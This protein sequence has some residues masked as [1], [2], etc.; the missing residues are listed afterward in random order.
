[1]K[2][3][4]SDTRVRG[5]YGLF[6]RSDGDVHAEAVGEVIGAEIAVGHEVVEDVPG[7]DED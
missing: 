1:M 4:C 3:T 7:D 2:I 6:A 5:S